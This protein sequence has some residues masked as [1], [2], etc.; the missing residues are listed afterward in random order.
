MNNSRYRNFCYQFDDP[1]ISEP[2]KVDI[3]ECITVNNF[4]KKVA[5]I[6]NIQNSKLSIENPPKEDNLEEITEKYTFK[7]KY[8]DRCDN[9]NFC[10]PD[11]KLYHIDDA[12]KMNFNQVISSLREKHIF[13][14][15]EM[16]R[17]HLHFKLYQNNLPKTEY[18]FLAIPKGASID[19]EYDCEA[20][21]LNYD[22]NKFIFAKNEAA[23][24]AY[25]LIKSAYEK[26]QN[27]TIT[28]NDTKVEYSDRLLNSNKYKISV[29][30]IVTFKLKDKSGLTQKLTLDYLSTVANA[31]K[32][33]R[34][35]YP[36]KNDCRLV[37]KDDKKDEMKSRDRLLR[38]GDRKN[39]LEKIFYF[40]F[41][42]KFEPPSAPASPNRPSKLSSSA[43][44][45]NDIFEEEEEE[46]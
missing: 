27:V 41:K 24:N 13:Y 3:N 45:V 10:L 31:Q 29:N 34:E 38:E 5:T 32:L 40:N 7:L 1:H 28:C 25:N 11:K 6:L 42:G 46:A 19:I 37:L 43:I 4:K 12:Y 39:F 35:K 18:P 16:A 26:S 30:F 2:I 22:Y 23:V 21:I 36:D 8:K 44:S 33:L 17:K 20:V 14:S 9:I 15:D